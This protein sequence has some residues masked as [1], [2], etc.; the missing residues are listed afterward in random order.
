M[1]TAV[2]EIHA[3]IPACVRVRDSSIDAILLAPARLHLSPVRDS[4]STSGTACNLSASAAVPPT[5][6]ATAE[7]P[8]VE[9]L[10][11]AAACAAAEVATDDVSASATP[12]GPA[13]MDVVEDDEGLPTVD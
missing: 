2:W 10:D 4:N 5:G 3:S 11:L 7:D 1:T 13:E 12:L 9:A 8:P 6:Q